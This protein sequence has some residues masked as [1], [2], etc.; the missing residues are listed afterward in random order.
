MQKNSWRRQAGAGLAAALLAAGPVA[1][2]A[3]DPGA[4]VERLT[5]MTA[6]SGYEQTLTDSLLRLIPGTR[7]DRAGNVVLV[8]GSG[9]PRRLVACGVDEPGYVVGAVRDDGWLTLKRVAFSSDPLVD[10]Q[11]EGQRITVFGRSGPVPGVVAVRSTHLARGRSSADDPFSVDGAYVDVGAASPSE[12]DKLGIGVLAPVALTKRPHRYGTDLLA[13]P[14]AGRRAA[15]AALASSAIRTHNVSGQT[16]VAFTVE[17]LF[18]RRGLLSVGNMMGPFAQ[19]YL[20]GAV[21]SPARGLVITTDTASRNP[22]LGA[23]TR[24]YLPVRYQGSPVETVS[25]EDVVNLSGRI[26]GLLEKKP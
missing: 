16:V 8:L 2:Q 25:L 6:V 9:E 1:G 15:C 26:D 19:T 18:T 22:S 14:G 4:L 11:L 21:S 17:E 24:W 10:Q 5:S 7:R 3:R 12:V 20:V 23:V 13:A